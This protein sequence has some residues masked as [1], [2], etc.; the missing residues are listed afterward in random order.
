MYPPQPPYQPSM[1]APPTSD[2]TPTA[3]TIQGKGGN[4]WRTRI[5]AAIKRRQ[6]YEPW[7]EACLKAYA[8]VASQDVDPLLYG[9][10]IRTN[11]TFTLVERKKAD[12]FYQR[13]DVTLQP[14]PLMDQPIQGFSLPA[15]PPQPGQPP[16][17]PQMVPQTYALEAHQEIVNEQLGDDGVDAAELMDA[18]T[19][20][21]VCHQ[22]IGFTKMGY[23]S[24]TVE[25][26][27]LDPMTGQPTTVPV[28]IA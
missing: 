24:Y 14:T 5:A 7:W 28:P 1:P 13:P 20:D 18:V 10:D 22:G 4:F 21:I 9:S 12:L 23:E 27:T 11:R 6:R 25:Q 2:M 3:T 15:P 8:P 17:Q 16:P 19:F 26:M